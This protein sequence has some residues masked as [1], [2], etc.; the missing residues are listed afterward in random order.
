MPK[1]YLVAPAQAGSSQTQSMMADV[2]DAFDI[3]CVRIPMTDASEEDLRRAVDV[4]RPVCHERDVPL[5]I[6]DHYRLASSL[7]LDGVHLRDGAR[8]VRAARKLLPEGSIIG[9]HARA[10]RHDG[11]LAAENGADY[12]AFGPLSPSSLGDGIIAEPDL[13]AWWS[14]MIEIPVVA[15]GGITPQ[16]AADICGITDFVALGEEL[17]SHPAGPAAALQAFIEQMH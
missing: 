3:A 8:N 13:F 14:D 11:M 5:L 7:G 16:I 12:I 17:W 1:L 15:E 10:S 6:T 2:L 9:A 4:L